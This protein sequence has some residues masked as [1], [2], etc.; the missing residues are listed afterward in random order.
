MNPDPLIDLLDKRDALV[1]DLANCRE[2]DALQFIE[3][4]QIREL[5]RIVLETSTE[6]TVTFSTT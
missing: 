3:N 1:S 5:G 2:L 4:E 6:E